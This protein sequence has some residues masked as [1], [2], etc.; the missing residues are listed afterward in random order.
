M[1]IKN[2]GTGITKKM[3]N[4]LDHKSSTM[5]D[6]LYT[7][8]TSKLKHKIGKEL[9]LSTRLINV[10]DPN[11][12]MLK[13]FNKVIP[14]F[15]E[16]YRTVD[17]RI[18]PNFMTM[19]KLSNDTF[20]YVASGTY[21][22]DYKNSL[23][24]N[25]DTNY[26]LY[27]FI[28]GKHC[29]WYFN[30]INQVI[31]KAEKKNLGHSLYVVNST[32]PRNYDITLLSFSNR[33]VESLVY[34]HNEDKIVTKFI[35]KFLKDVDYYEQKQ[36]NYKTGI[37]LYSEPGTGKSSLVKALACKYKRSICQVNIGTIEKV[38]FNELTSMINADSDKYIVLFEDIDTLYLN[39]DKVTEEGKNYNDI[40]NGLLQF[41]D[42]TSSPNNV[43]FIG[44][45]NHYDRL[46]PALI[47]DGRFDLKLEVKPLEKSDIARFC[48]TLEFNGSVDDVI[49]AYGEP[50]ENGHYNQ[51]KLQNIILQLR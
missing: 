20:V 31:A 6:Y 35:D 41:L 11:D 13:L 44:T 47:R 15:S 43:I 23:F 3:I 46:D 16:K 40:I 14:G 51:S 4:D 1:A 19:N 29:D 17:G 33:D 49:K 42:S 36:L 18:L 48:K 45:T 37:L 38:N 8:G 24:F 22:P 9:Y 26:D 7:L 27:M 21:I 12:I 25:K 50:D 34:S 39:R 28:F 32:I 5:E 2:F 10:D 30:K